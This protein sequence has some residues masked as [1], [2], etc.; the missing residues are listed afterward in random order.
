MPTALD[1]IR[2]KYVIEKH[3]EEE[4]IAVCTPMYNSM[5]F[6][7]EYLTH[8]INYDYPKDLLS[9]YFTVQGKDGTY[10]TLKEFKAKFGD[11]YRKIKFKREKQVRGRNMPHVFNLVRLRNTLIKWSKPDTVFFNDHDNFNPPV[12]IKRLREGLALGASIAAGP[13]AF[14]QKDPS[15]KKGKISFTTFYLKE[16]KKLYALTLQGGLKGYFPLEMFGKRMWVDAVACGCT[17]MSRELLDELQF[18][19]PHETSMSDDTAFCLKAR[20]MGHRIISDLGL[21][22]QHWGFDIEFNQVMQVNVRRHPEMVM[23]RD[24]MRDDGVYVVP[25]MDVDMDAAVRKYIDLDKI[26]I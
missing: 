16:D 7:D 15:E 22:V 21:F 8:V 10:D 12:S 2:K 25:N 17:M 5:P 18:F 6:L 19:V 1:L 11:E 26:N 23:R 9:L 20:E 4:P 3:V 13:Y 14:F 24:K